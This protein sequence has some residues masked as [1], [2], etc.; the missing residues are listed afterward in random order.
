MKLRLYSPDP[1]DGGSAGSTDQT[2]PTP[3]PAPAAP[4]AARTVK[5]GERTER[6]LQLEKDLQA[7]NDREARTAAEKK[8]RE[9]RINQLEDELRQLK[10]IPK[11]EPAKKSSGFRLTLLEDEEEEPNA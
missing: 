3:S 7:A 8:D 4:P 1:T 11:T 9:Q 6:E 2:P 10:Q 5:E